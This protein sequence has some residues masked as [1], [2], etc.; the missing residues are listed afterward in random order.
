ML[1][2]IWHKLVFYIIVK[3]CF[4]FNKEFS[5]NN[6]SKHSRVKLS[7]VIIDYFFLLM[8]TAL[9]IH[10]NF[11]QSLST[12]CL[13]EKNTFRFSRIFPSNVSLFSIRNMSYFIV[14]FEIHRK[15]GLN[16]LSFNARIVYTKKRCW[17]TVTAKSF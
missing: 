11:K 8:N 13:L 15:I 7:K 14:L 3:I 17:H 5:I 16:L 4:S 6:N 2:C 9:R 1:Y 10:I 12:L